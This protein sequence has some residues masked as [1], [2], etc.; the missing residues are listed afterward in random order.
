MTQGHQ[1]LVLQLQLRMVEA[2][3]KDPAIETGTMMESVSLRLLLHH[4]PSTVKFF[5]LLY[6]N[7]P[8]Q[9]LPMGYFSERSFN[10]RERFRP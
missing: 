9:V 3:S 7:Q 4:N 10:L 2:I 8:Q 6:L 1:N 5:R